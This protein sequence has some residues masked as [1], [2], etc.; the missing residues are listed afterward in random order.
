MSRRW[1]S[2]TRWRTYATPS[3]EPDP[4]L[5]DYPQ[6]PWVSR[7]TLPAKGWDDPLLRRN[8]GDT[9]HEQEEVLSMW[10]PDVAPIP[11]KQALFQFTLAALGFVSFGLLVK[12]VLAQEPPAIRREYPFDGLV[13]ELGG[14]EETKA[15]VE[16]LETDL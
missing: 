12:N 3:Q 2:L 4:Q 8:F 16:S 9:L 15:R 11:P 5:G 13:T 7:Q 10:G 6:L 1:R 14:H